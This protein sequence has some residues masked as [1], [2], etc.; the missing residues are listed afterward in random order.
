LIEPP[1]RKYIPPFE[2]I[3]AFDAVARLGGIR[4]AAI[5]LQRDHAVVGRHLRSLEEWVGKQLV[6]RNSSGVVLT[7]HG[8]AYHAEIAQAMDLIASATIDLMRQGDNNRIN[9]RCA[10]GFAFYWLSRKISGFETRY[11]DYDIELHPADRTAIL[12]AKDSD[13][14]IRFVSEYGIALK[15]AQGLINTCIG[16]V[17][18][19]AVASPEYLASRPPINEPRDLLACKLL[20]EHDIDAWANW[21]AVYGVY[22]DI[23]LRGPRLWQGHLTLDA[24]IRGQGVALINALVAAD[25]LTSGQLCQLGAGSELFKPYVFGKYYMITHASRSDLPLI[26]RFQEWLTKTVSADIERVNSTILDK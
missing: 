11:P 17:P 9:I 26:R 12:V 22:A 13:V 10:P 18:I 19:I 25:S 24:T 20:H 5:S 21:L 1:S 23:D 16:E 8:E 4:K 14:D 3:R 15:P 2:S 7:E 6:E